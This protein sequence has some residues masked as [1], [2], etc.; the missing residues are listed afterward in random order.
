MS[1]ARKQRISFSLLSSGEKIESKRLKSAHHV[2]VRYLSRALSLSRRDEWLS[3]S[4]KATQI[5]PLFGP[6]TRK[7][8]DYFSFLIDRERTLRFNC[9]VYFS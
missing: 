5:S 1:S 3:S 2:F 6:I 9:W 8:H 7:F 4:L